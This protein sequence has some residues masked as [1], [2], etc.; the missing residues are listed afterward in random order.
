MADPVFRTA[1]QATALT[2]PHIAPINRFV[3]SIRDRDRRGW[4]PYVA[5]L[6]GGVDAQVLSI[7]RD[8]GPATQDDSG[9]G[10]LAIE[11]DDP[12]AERQVLL[13]ESAGIS[14][15]QVLPWNAYPWYF[16]RKPTGAELDAGAQVIVELLELL[17]DLRVVLLQGRDAEA[18]WRKVARRLPKPIE[19]RGVTV[20]ATIHPGRQALFTPDRDE[21]ARRVAHQET[22]FARV[23]E[24]IRGIPQGGGDQ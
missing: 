11:N 12:T 10:F 8:P 13:F 20:L 14:P 17:P 19:E 15:R 2:A 16:N 24:L 7:L 3:D 1:Q 4:A 9:S 5:P 22:T 6:H 21:R 18:G 23:G